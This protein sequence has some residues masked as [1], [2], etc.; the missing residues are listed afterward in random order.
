MYEK[1]E[2][3]VHKINTFWFVLLNL[4]R[5]G[6]SICIQ[7]ISVMQG[8]TKGSKKKYKEFTVLNI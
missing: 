8:N 2:A 7:V 3:N 6:H 1:K 5:G 4:L